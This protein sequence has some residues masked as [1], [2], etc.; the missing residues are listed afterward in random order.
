M[1]IYKTINKINGKI[2]V[3]QQLNEI[4]KPNYLGSGKIL[5][6]AIKKNDI[7]NF[8]KIVL[9]KCSSQEELNEREIFWIK[10]L[11]ATDSKIGYNLA[12]GGEVRSIYDLP[13]NSQKLYKKNIKLNGKKQSERKRAGL[14]TEAELA[15]RKIVSMKLKGSGIG[16]NI[17]GKLSEEKR[18]EWLRKLKISGKNLSKRRLSGNFTKAELEGYK[19]ISI[20]SKGEKSY[21]WDGYIY[22]YDINNKLVHKF[23][24]IK[25]AC[26]TLHMRQ[27][28][29]NKLANTNILYKRFHKKNHLNDIDNCYIIRTKENLEFK[30]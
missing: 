12:P 13:L 29:I 17:V 5:K 1:I 2:Y 7:K 11:N 6:L 18:K 9:E 30:N 22:I 19:K 28:I 10:E 14:F 20:S 15:G 27:A 23:I 16:G 26:K 25:E 4:K 8:E 21:N 24:T 3:G